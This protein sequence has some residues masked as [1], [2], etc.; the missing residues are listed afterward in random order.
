MALTAPVVL[1]TVLKQVLKQGAT[2]THQGRGSLHQAER[3][4]RQRPESQKDFW[5]DPIDLRASLRNHSRLL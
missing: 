4:L 1:V 2:H 5:P 3:L